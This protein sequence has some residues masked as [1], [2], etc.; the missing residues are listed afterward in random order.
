MQL[1]AG[2][3]GKERK[4]RERK[5][6]GEKQEVGEKEER[7]HSVYMQPSLIFLLPVQCFKRTHMHP[8]IPPSTHTHTPTTPIFKITI[9]ASVKVCVY[10]RMISI[11]NVMY[12]KHTESLDHFITL[13]HWLIIN[14]N[15]R[16]AAILICRDGNFISVMNR[17]R[18]TKP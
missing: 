12:S 4:R 15:N 6:I 9:S 11:I 2:E 7:A 1:Q 10:D 3:T 17:K 16:F 8:T 18:E 5:H 14:P 13:C